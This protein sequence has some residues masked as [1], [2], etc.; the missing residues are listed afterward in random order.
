[1][2]TI[3]I[4]S[5]L[6]E[7]FGKEATLA[8][9]LMLL[10]ASLIAVLGLFIF[11]PTEWNELAFWKTS[12]LFLLIFDVFAGFI[13]NLTLSTNNYYQENRKLRLVFIA[14]HIQPLI[15]AL[16]L[17]GYFQVCLFIWAYTVAA[18]FFVNAMKAYPAQKTLAASLV[19]LGLT[20]LLLVSHG[21]PLV[22]LTALVFYHLKVV[23]SFSV[24]QYAPREI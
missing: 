23:Y 19:T 3:K 4:P 12:L 15:F 20:G 17:G 5:F 13:A 22:L 1:M 8:E 6:Y 11:T 16:L 9:I 24:D 18:A 14:I 10:L 7:V 21:L 2:K